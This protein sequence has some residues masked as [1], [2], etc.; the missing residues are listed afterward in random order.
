M[1]GVM[2][3]TPSLNTLL[4]DYRAGDFAIRDEVTIF[5]ALF[6]GLPTLAMLAT[7]AMA[8]S[9]LVAI[10]LVVNEDAGAARSTCEH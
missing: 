1:I 2:D 8:T 9:P 3:A 5:A 7:A 6:A 10:D 4:S